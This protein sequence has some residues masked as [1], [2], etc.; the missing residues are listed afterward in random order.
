MEKK[1]DRGKR[2]VQEQAQLFRCPL[3]HSAMAGSTGGLTCENQH[4]FDVSKKGTLFFLSHQVKTDY[5]R[6]MFAARRR[7]IQSGMYR[8]LLERLAEAVPE[9]GTLLD[10]GCGEGSFLDL[11]LAQ[12]SSQAAIGFDISKEGVY[13]ATEQPQPAFWCV[14]DL[15]NLPFAQERFDT[16]LNIFSPSNYREFARI[17]KPKGQLLKVV[18]GPRYLQELRQAFYPDDVNKQQYSNEPVVAKFT[19]SYRTFEKE[20]ITYEFEIPTERRLDLLEMSPLEWGVDPA[21]KAAL[22][23]QPLNKITVDLLLLK[24]EN[25]AFL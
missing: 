21:R 19:E 6:E 25:S 4:R 15:T 9:N 13:M 23:K 14:A 16:V 17:L 22:K 2:F 7:M 5:D 8:P 3:C 18:P 1:I 12:V 24:A 11:L 10:V 20:E